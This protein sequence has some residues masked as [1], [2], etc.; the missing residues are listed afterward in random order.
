MYRIGRVLH[1][2]PNGNI[3]LKAENLPQMGERVVDE[4]RKLV[5]TISDIFGPINFPYVVVKANSGKPQH[6]LDLVLYASP[7]TKNKM[8]K[9][10]KKT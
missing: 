1:V 10:R 6:P 4:S 5:G 9:R 7:I 2:S 8:R 3:I